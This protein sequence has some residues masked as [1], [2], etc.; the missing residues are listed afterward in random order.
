MLL[1]CNEFCQW[2]VLRVGQD[3]THMGVT[4][5]KWIKCYKY[6]YCTGPLTSRMERIACVPVS[7][8]IYNCIPG[9]VGVAV[10]A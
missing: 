5:Y 9:R 8:K 1:L 4:C 10:P 6:S 2:Y 7:P 3:S